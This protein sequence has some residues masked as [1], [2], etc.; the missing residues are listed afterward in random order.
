MSEGVTEERVGRR[1]QLPASPKV[2]WV[3][4]RVSDIVWVESGRAVIYDCGAGQ[5]C[6]LTRL[7]SL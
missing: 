1:F 7:L 6:T 4:E 2:R 3:N 5:S